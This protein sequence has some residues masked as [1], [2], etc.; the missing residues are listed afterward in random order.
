[1]DNKNILINR[2]L[3]NNQNILPRPINRNNLPMVPEGNIQSNKNYGV[4]NKYPNR[5]SYPTFCNTLP[6]PPR[7]QNITDP[8][9]QMRK[10]E[11]CSYI[12]SN[13]FDKNSC[14]LSVNNSQNVI[15]IF[16][17]GAGGSGNSNIARGNEFGLEYPISSQPIQ[18][19]Y[20]SS[21]QFKHDII[22]NQ[23][24]FYPY[25]SQMNIHNPMYKSYPFN[26]TY[27]DNGQPTFVYP[28]RPVNG[29]N[30][31]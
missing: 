28:Y 22:K 26:N 12:P 14:Y 16:C 11:Q 1:M 6:P 30:N 29:L 31:N 27:A 7:D 18:K 20:A 23:S 13:L 3:P 10:R 2:Q 5:D 17:G 19:Y 21:E 15:G 25:F 8:I 24:I 9:R 4:F